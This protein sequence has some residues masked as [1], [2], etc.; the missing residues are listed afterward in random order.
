MR[1]HAPSALAKTPPKLSPEAFR[2]ME[3]KKYRKFYNNHT[4]KHLAIKVCF[5]ISILCEPFLSNPQTFDLLA[6]QLESQKSLVW[7]SL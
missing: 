4:I 1:G 5:V 2:L 3:C 6:G 7:G